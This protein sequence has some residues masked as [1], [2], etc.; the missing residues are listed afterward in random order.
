VVAEQFDV[1]SAN[2]HPLPPLAI[3]SAPRSLSTQHASP[4]QFHPSPSQYPSPTSPFV[5]GGLP[6]YR[7]SAR[8]NTIASI[9]APYPALYSR[10]PTSPLRRARSPPAV[11]SGRWP[12]PP[13]NTVQLDPRIVLDPSGTLPSPPPTS[14][15]GFATFR[16]SPTPPS[17]ATIA[18]PP[19]SFSTS[20]HHYPFAAARADIEMR[21]YD[22]HG[23]PPEDPG[24]SSDTSSPER[25][26]GILV[27]DWDPAHSA[28][29]VRA[30]R[31]R[32]HEEERRHECARCHKRFS[33]P[34][35]LRIH[36]NTHTGHK[37]MRFAFQ[38][39]LFQS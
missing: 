29:G 18:L 17:S 12:S 9:N 2:R 3:P 22:P 8:R 16:L 36:E 6:S 28:S 7:P 31:R 13:T 14:R 27:G 15:P 25:T 11:S 21:F 26:H 5:G 37:R 20:H 24:S 33:R 39:P 1:P 32:R 38:L 23:G 10:S 30:P 4:T 35:S 34:S 19:S